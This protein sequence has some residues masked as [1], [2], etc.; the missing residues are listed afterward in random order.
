MDGSG[1]LES[2]GRKEKYLE[3]SG[4]RQLRCRDPGDRESPQND[5][6][7]GEGTY[8]IHTDCLAAVEAL[9]RPS[10]HRLVDQDTT[11]GVQSFF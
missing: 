6:V 3:R 4:K 7:K 11:K 1:R 9:G 10:I 5:E 2:I 8:R